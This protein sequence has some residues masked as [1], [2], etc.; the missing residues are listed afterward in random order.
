MVHPTY[1]I[2]GT[3]IDASN[4]SKMSDNYEK[5]RA[6]FSDMKLMNY[7]EIKGIKR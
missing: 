3:L 4:K 6:K 5:I 2:D 7:G 1:S